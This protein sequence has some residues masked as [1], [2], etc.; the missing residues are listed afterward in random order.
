MNMIGHQTVS[1]DLESE[2]SAIADQCSQVVLPVPDSKEDI[3]SIVAPLRYMMRKPYCNRSR[4]PR[5]DNSIRFMLFEVKWKYGKCPRISHFSSRCPRLQWS[6]QWSVHP[7]VGWSVQWRVEWSVGWSVY[8]SV[9][10]SVHWSVR[11]SVH[12]SIHWSVHR[13][14]GW[15]L[16]PSVRWSVHWSVHPSVGGMLHPSTPAEMGSIGKTRNLGDLA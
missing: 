13:S 12:P 3:G 15:R 9:G 2:L 7:S 6:V 4:Y 8:R 5:H 10:C 1:P 11:W 16:Y 14:A